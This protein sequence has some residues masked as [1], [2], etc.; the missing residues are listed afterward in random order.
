MNKQDIKAF[1]FLLSLFSL[2]AF[3]LGRYIFPI[4]KYIA[5]NE[6]SQKCKELGGQFNI[7]YDYSFETKNGRLGRANPDRLI[8]KCYKERETLFKM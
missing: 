4:E 7:S 3:L 8:F 5:Q 2:P 1:L 6:A